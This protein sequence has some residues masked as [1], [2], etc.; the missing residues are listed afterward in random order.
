MDNLKECPFCGHMIPS[1]ASICMFC[2]GEIHNTTI[3]EKFHRKAFNGHYGLLTT[4]ITIG[5]IILCWLYFTLS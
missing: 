1:F 2:N 4:S 3:L 5:F